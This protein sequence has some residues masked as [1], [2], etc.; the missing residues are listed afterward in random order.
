VPKHETAYTK[1]LETTFG[2]RFDLVNKADSALD[3]QGSS[4]IPSTLPDYALGKVL[5]TQLSKTELTTSVRS[6]LSN[7]SSEVSAE[8]KKLLSDWLSNP[9]DSSLAAKIS[10]L[11]DESPA[12]S[13]IKLQASAFTRS[14][15][16]IIGSDAWSYDLGTSGVHHALSSNANVNLLIIDSQPYDGPE[17]VQDPE[18][19]AKKDVGLYAMNYGNA[20]VA[21]VAVYGDYSQTVRAFVEADKFDGPAVVLAY[22]PKGDNDASKALE[23]LK[24]T[25][26][27]IDSGFWPL[28]RWNPHKEVKR[29]PIEG[30]DGAPMVGGRGWQA[31]DDED[32]FQL[33]SEK[34]KTDLRAFLDRQNI[35]TQF[36]LNEP[37][38]ADSIVGSFGKKIQDA[39][40]EKARAA[41]EKLSGAIDGPSLLVLYASDGGNAE[42]VAKRFTA[43]ARA[44]GL[45][46]RV[47]VMDEFSFED[48]SIEPNVALFTS[49]AGQGEFPNNGRTFWK[50]LLS[51]NPALGPS[52][53]EGKSLSE[54]KYSVFG[55]GDSHYWPRPEDAHY[56][57]KSSKDL[58]AKLAGLGAQRFNDLGLG[59]DQDA[60]GYQTG[61]KIWEAAVWKSFGVD[62]V[63]I[64]EAE[65]EPVTNEHIKIASNYLRGTIAEGLKDTSTGALAESDGQ[66]TK[67]HGIYQQDDRDIREQRKDE[68]LEPAYSFMVRVRMPAGVCKPEQWLA[69]NEI[70]DRRGNHTFKLTTRQTFQFHGII[71]SNL[72]PAIQE[73]NRATL[74]TVAACGDVNR[75]VMC[76]ANPS[77]GPLHKQVH[78]FATH[79]SEHLMPQTTAYSEIWLDQK[80]VAGDAVKAF[81][82]PLYGQ[83]YLPRKFKIAVAVPPHNDVDVFCNDVGFIA[84]VD[85]SSGNLQGFNVSIGGGMGV[86]HAMKTT[87]PRLGDVIGF[88]TPEQGV[89]VAEKIM[90]VQRDN[91][92]RSNRKNARLKYT[93]DRMGLDNFVA[94]MESRLGYRLQPAKEFKFDSNIDEFGWTT[95]S[96]GK[97][98]CTVFIEN[99]RV[100]DAPGKP[101]KTGLQKIAEIHKG[102]FRLTG[103]QHLIISDVATEDKPAIEKLMKEHN[104]DKFD[105]SGLRLS[106]SACVAFPTCG[107]AMAES[108]RFLPGLID[109]VEKIMEDQGLR[110][111]SIVMRVTGC[112]NGCARPYA[113]EVA[114]VGKAPDS[115]LMLLGGGYKGDRLNKIYKE[116]VSEEEIVQILTPMIKSYAKNRMQGEPFGDYSIRAGWVK[117]TFKGL[118]WYEGSGEHAPVEV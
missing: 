25:K 6:L 8:L 69:I 1:I 59:D 116:A 31:T 51:A 27:A 3:A 26:L 49:T 107:L 43:R 67:F 75:N 109:R 101:Q 108:E 63:K 89:D 97:H 92:N 65:P 19:R 104:L 102:V 77:I 85:P 30:G 79:I 90:L 110:H 95:G 4:T 57:N 38:L 36:S 94:D 112:P 61:Y 71:K 52:G 44:R 113:A 45:G 22:L 62:D 24:E 29:A 111:D 17:S 33:D 93:I 13:Q 82:E 100:E 76:G 32:A 106:S 58:D 50:A 118:D 91:G 55:M 64:V 18:R 117:K 9:S 34:I 12:L 40:D 54:V 73:I 74:D 2:S 103:N 16:W 81:T 23:V 114:F 80:M 35:L 87:Y 105:F 48:L 72:K 42:K 53:G 98:H 88:C 15:Q 70:S 21:S 11:L 78:D 47:V 14:S 41:F 10:P 60:D 37:K 28:Y 99:G 5:A 39:V 46:A 7:P 86:T 115:Y 83:Y 20:Y 84:I 68:G 96:D 66:L 56:Y